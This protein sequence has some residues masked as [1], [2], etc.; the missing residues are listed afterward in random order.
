MF[1]NKPEGSASEL[2]ACMTKACG[3]VTGCKLQSTAKP[4]NCVRGLKVK[5]IMCYS[6]REGPPFPPFEVLL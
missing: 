2:S 6:K 5:C 3:H 4:Q 1:A